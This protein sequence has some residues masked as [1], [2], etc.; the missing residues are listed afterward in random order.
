MLDITDIDLLMNLP[1][2]KCVVSFMLDIT[3]I[4]LLI[5]L[6]NLKCVVYYIY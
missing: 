3:D 6:P 4:D 5:N 2:F 1:S